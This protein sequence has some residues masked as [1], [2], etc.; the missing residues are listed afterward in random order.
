ML[1]KVKVLK[2]KLQSEYYKNLS[3]HHSKKADEFLEKGMYEESEYHLD[4]ST[5][6]LLKRIDT[7]MEYSK[8]VL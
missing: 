2:L 1:A 8:A 4:L 3:M 6:Y 7:A 5:A